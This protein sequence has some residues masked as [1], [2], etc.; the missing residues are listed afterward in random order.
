M[1]ERS[2]AELVHGRVEADSTRDQ[3]TD[4]GWTADKDRTL[5]WRETSTARRRKKTKVSNP[6]NPTPC[7]SLAVNFV[8]VLIDYRVE[9]TGSKIKDGLSIDSEREMLRER[10]A[11]LSISTTICNVRNPKTRKVGL[12]ILTVKNINVIGREPR[13]VRSGCVWRGVRSRCVWTEPEYKQRIK[14]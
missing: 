3:M 12:L 10:N 6:R 11:I 14:P 5:D 13:G 4:K 2:P 8:C 1:G 9:N 7:L